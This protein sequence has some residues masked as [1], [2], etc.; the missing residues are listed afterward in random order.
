MTY[1]GQ[2]AIDYLSSKIHESDPGCSSHW[3]QYH[4]S[5]EFTGK[6][7]EGL[8]GFG[9]LSPA[10]SGLKSLAH[11]ILQVRFRNMGKCFPSFKS[12]DREAKNITYSQ[13]RHYDLDVLRQSLSVSLLQKTIP[14]TLSSN[15]WLVLLGMDLLR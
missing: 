15:L 3:Q 6:E 11:Q 10:L 12:V 14:T 8:E 5:F 7:F 9:G 4:S 13:N 2:S 1:T